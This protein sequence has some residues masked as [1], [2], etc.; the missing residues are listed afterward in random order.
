MDRTYNIRGSN[1]SGKTVATKAA[2]CLGSL[3]K[4]RG[5]RD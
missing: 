5:T 2:K 3:R 4:S 1:K